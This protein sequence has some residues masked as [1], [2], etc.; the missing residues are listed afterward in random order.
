MEPKLGLMKTAELTKDGETY[1]ITIDPETNEVFG[2]RKNA[3]GSEQKFKKGKR[4]ALFGAME[5]AKKTYNGLVDEGW[6]T[7]EVNFSGA[8]EA[9]FEKELGAKP[10][11]KKAVKKDTKPAPPPPPT[12]KQLLKKSPA[13]LCRL[14]KAELDAAHAELK[15]QKSA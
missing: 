8:A 5:L 11:K 10:K 12:V 6:E 3:D 1:T 9:L 14:A 13:D 4:K 2:T 15:K 7:V